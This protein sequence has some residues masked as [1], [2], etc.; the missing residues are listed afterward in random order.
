MLKPTN[1][2]TK[3][4]NDINKNDAVDSPK[5]AICVTVYNEDRDAL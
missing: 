3:N 5:V 1:I 4:N 2:L